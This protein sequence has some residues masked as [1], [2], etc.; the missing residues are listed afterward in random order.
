MSTVG[1]GDVYAKTTLGRLFMVF[2]ILG[3][4]AMFASYVPEIIELIGNRKKYG[5]SYSAA[6][7][8]RYVPEIAALI[9][10]RNKFGG[11]F[12]KHGGRK[13]LHAI[14]DE[15]SVWL[16]KR[17]CFLLG[18]YFSVCSDHFITLSINVQLQ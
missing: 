7:F 10:N 2:F 14:P 8:A 3:G 13:V 4:L 9:L 16:F 1:Y 17:E 18:N 12:N 6:M 5:G 15:S 11:T